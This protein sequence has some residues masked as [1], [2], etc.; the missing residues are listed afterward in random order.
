MA[1]IEQS[2]K[3]SLSTR[4]QEDDKGSKVSPAVGQENLAAVTPP[5]ESYEGHHRFDPTATWTEDEER[6][7]IW[8]TDL[9]LMTWLCLMF[10]GLQL[11]RGNL[12]NALTDN[13]LDD[14]NMTT[15]DY[16]NTGAT[17]P[18]AALEFG[19]LDS[20]LDDEPSILLRDQS[21]NWGLR[22]R[23]HSRH[24]L[25]RDI[26]LQDKG[27]LHP[28]VLFLVHFEYRPYHFVFVGGWY[29]RD[30]GDKGTHWLV[31]AV[32]DR[33]ALDV[34]HRTFRLV[35]PPQFAD[36]NQECPIP[37]SMVYRT[38]RGDNDQRKSSKKPGNA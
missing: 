21:A 5:H 4:A 15:D 17:H 9:M 13:F 27:A 23:L 24:N 35:L 14:L 12:S 6:R 8:K 3:S 29:P 2:G 16:N 37:Q 11:D 28:T 36:K 18:D 31:L 30:E 38:P 7:V 32:P 10:F 33:R 26:L 34:R 25:V 20:V 1:D 19:L 22:G